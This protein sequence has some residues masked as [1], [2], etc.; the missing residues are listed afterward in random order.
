MPG[1]VPSDSTSPA[2][3]TPAG[4]ACRRLS[5]WLWE[6]APVCWGLR[7]GWGGWC[8]GCS[9]HRKSQHRPGYRPARE[10][11]SEL[12]GKGKTKTA[13]QRKGY[14][15]EMGLHR[16]PAA[17]RAVLWAVGQCSPSSGSLAGGNLCAPP[18]CPV[19]GAALTQ[20]A[21]ESQG[22][23]TEVCPLPALLTSHGL[24]L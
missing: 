1:G 9:R 11:L 2:L 7:E 12:L 13:T 19:P 5:A 23:S 14:A 21:P 15:S 22:P 3:T 8:C 10:C 17:G 16:P 6:A 18:A 20:P 4:L 24:G